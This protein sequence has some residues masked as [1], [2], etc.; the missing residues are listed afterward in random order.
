MKDY[1]AVIY[2]ISVVTVYL[3]VSHLLKGMK[4]NSLTQMNITDTEC[5]IF[6]NDNQ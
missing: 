6:Y 4:K 3:I 2:R 1:F 5:K